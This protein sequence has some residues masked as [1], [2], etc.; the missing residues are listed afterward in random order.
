MTPPPHRRQRKSN[1]VRAG[2]DLYRLIP[3][4]LTLTALCAGATSLRFAWEGQWEWA[5]GGICLAALLDALDGRIARLIG[6]TSRFGSELDSL[7]DVVNFGVAPGLLLYLY[8]LHTIPRLGW[9]FAMAFIL[10]GTLRLARF[11]ILAQAPPSET[12]KDFFLGIPITFAALLSLLPMMWDFQGWG[13]I[14]AW[15]VGIYMVLLSLGMISRLPTF[16]FKRVRLTP[17]RILIAL[18][19]MVGI[20]LG[21]LSDVWGTLSLICVGYLA[22]LPVSVSK[23]RKLQSLKSSED[24]SLSSSTNGALDE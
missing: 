24:I 1:R 12:L 19:V 15:I 3:N 20:I 16:S 22:L 11:N 6:A 8:T 5:A 7:A 4:F 13:R 18:L 21:V 2:I 17:Q 23:A 14:P 10:C 9:V